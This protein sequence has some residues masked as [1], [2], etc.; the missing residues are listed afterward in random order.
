VGEQA[1]AYGGVAGVF[2]GAVVV[3]GR[4][5]CLPMGFV[6]QWKGLAMSRC[7]SRAVRAGVVSAVLGRVLASAALAVGT[8][9]GRMIVG[10]AARPRALPVPGYGVAAVP[11]GDADARASDVIR[12]ESA[13]ASAHAAD[14]AYYAVARAADVA[15]RAAVVAAY[16]AAASRVPCDTGTSAC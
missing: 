2:P 1:V 8:P 3:L 6:A 9:S 12:T 10:A 13:S 14:N 11:A 7:S 4:G 5:V 15:H 16:A